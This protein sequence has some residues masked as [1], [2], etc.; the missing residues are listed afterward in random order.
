MSTRYYYIIT[1]THF[2][3]LWLQTC[4]NHFCRYS[5]DAMEM[6][7]DNKWVIK[8]FPD[9]VRCR[10]EKVGDNYYSGFIP[11]VDASSNLGLIFNQNLDLIM[12]E[13][14]HIN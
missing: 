4:F 6:I 14:I 3:N 12:I 13:L 8:E 9:L 5:V 1:G 10:S 11:A 7:H 2:Y